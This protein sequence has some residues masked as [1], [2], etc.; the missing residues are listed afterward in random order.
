[1]SQLRYKYQTIEF[2]YIDIHV[3]TLKDS[4]QFFDKDNIAEKLGI[5][6]AS[7]SLFGVIW[8]SAKVLANFIFKFE[9]SSKKI[10]E[11]GCGIGLSSLL[12]NHMGED[13]TATD[14]HP[15]VESYLLNNSQL[16][17]DKKIPFFRVD[18]E[19]DT[20]K[21]EKYDIIIGSDL[22]YQRDHIDLLSTFINTHAQ[23]KCE[24]IIVD[25]NRGNQSKFTQKMLSFGFEH[26][27][28]DTQKYSDQ[29]FK[30]SIHYYRRKV[31]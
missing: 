25:P 21:L 19:N 29:N 20:N 2:D 5:N 11:V 17:N 31:N 28:I 10:L 3:K 18:W 13:V 9:T 27:K 4:Q 14:Y 24:I 12:L 23:S 26:Q 15:E 1:M 6:S 8:P 7:W 30:G 16:N 22:L